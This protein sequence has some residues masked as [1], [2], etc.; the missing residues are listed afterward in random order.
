[1]RPG[2][3]SKPPEPATEN[4]LAALKLNTELLAKPDAPAPDRALAPR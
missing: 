1:M 2:E 4:L 3:I